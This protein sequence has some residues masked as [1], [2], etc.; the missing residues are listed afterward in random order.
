LD[1]E[2]TGLSPHYGDRICEIGILRCKGFRILSEYSTLINPQRPISPGAYA[3]NR[4]TS[5][6]V[7]NA[8][9]FSEVIDKVLEF[10]SDAVIVCHNVN[11]DLKFLREEFS[12]L[13]IPQPENHYICTLKI[14]RRYFSFPSNSLQVIADYLGVRQRRRHRALEDAYTT[15][16]IFKYYFKNLSNKGWYLEQF[17]ELSKEEF[18]KEKFIS[19]PPLIEE[20]MKSKLFLKIEYVSKWGEYTERIIEPKEITKEKD[21]LYLLGFC[22]LRGEERIFRLDRIVKMEKLL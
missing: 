14:A 8:P 12:I 21:Y 20:A 3:V 19:L 16:E 6:M 2:T 7:K 5:E 10:L 1:L 4:I 22:K 17:F 18:K 11:F 13:N 15:R 9:L